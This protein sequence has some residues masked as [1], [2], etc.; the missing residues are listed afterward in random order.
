MPIGDYRWMTRQEMDA[1]DWARYDE[2]EVTD[3][4][5]SVTLRYPS[6]LHLAHNSLPLAPHFM[7]IDQDNLSPFMRQ[8]LRENRGT[9]KHESKKLVS[10]FL[11]REEYTCHAYNLSLYLGLGME[12]VKVHK[13]LQFTTSRFLERYIN[14]CTTKRQQATSDF[15]KRLFKAFSNR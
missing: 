3:Y 9:D 1:R 12:L 7:N 4:V 2:N 11:P 5:V 13:A 14:Y 10:T 6:H 8:V 15:R